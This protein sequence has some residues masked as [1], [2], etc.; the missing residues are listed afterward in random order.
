MS[1]SPAT[2]SMLPV[3]DK[4]MVR[5]EA[6]QNNIKNVTGKNKPPAWFADF[7]KSLDIFV[8]DVSIAV[9]E[10]DTRYCQLEGSFAI[11]KAIIDG[12]DKDRQSLN[13]K[14]RE[15]EVDLEDQRQYSR[16]TNILVHG[17]DEEPRE[18]TDTKVLEVLKDK[19]GLANMTLK[20]IS[21]SHRLGKKQDG[22]K[23]PVIVRFSSYRERKQAF[24][25]KKKLR[26][27][28]I[29][30]TESLTKERYRLY[31]KCI[32]QYNK[33]NVWTLDGRIYIATDEIGNNGRNKRICVTRDEDLI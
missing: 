17:L 4:F 33:E 16:R 28:G 27:S 3:F 24:D 12:L 7:T 11:Q 13:G 14:I 29:V 5:V 19:L 23:R 1:Q 2:V 18:N 8:N 25:S 30:I 32:D 15:L 6:F 26:A 20:D 9:K 22:K 31:K 10:L 21:R